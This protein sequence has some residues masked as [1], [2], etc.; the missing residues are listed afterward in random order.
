MKTN[1]T[2]RPEP[3]WFT[4]DLADR[5]LAK[6]RSGEC[7]GWTYRKVDVGFSSYEIHAYDED[8]IHC[9]TF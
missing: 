9:G 4:S 8:G 5:V 6:L 1:R 3:T 7:D 2:P